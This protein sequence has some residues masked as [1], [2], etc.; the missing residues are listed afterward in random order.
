MFLVAVAAAG[1]VFSRRTLGI[2]RQS[3]NRSSSPGENTGFYVN[4]SVADEKCNRG[5]ARNCGKFI[6]GLRDRNHRGK[7]SATLVEPVAQAVPASSPN[8]FL[9][10]IFHTGVFGVGPVL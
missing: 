6:N 7:T 10:T 8:M 3:A 4:R 9:P 5:A 2:L 1:L